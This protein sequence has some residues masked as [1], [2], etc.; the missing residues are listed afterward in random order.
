M[1]SSRGKQISRRRFLEAGSLAAGAAAAGRFAHGISLGTASG[2]ATTPLAE[3][4]YGDVDLASDLHETQLRETHAVLMALS[5][6]SLLKPFRQM[7]GQAAP[8]ED[9][10]GWYHYDPDWNDHRD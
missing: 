4:G 3:F 2:A 6:D 1:G 10:G 8:G 7:S 5:D 9:L